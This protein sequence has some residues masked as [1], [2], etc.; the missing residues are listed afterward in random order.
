MTDNLENFHYNVIIANMHEMYSF[1]NKQIE[2]DIN[3]ETLINNYTKILI[4]INPIIPHYSNECLEMIGSKDE[5]SWPTYENKYLE[6][7][8]INIVVQ[9]N[10]KK[11]ALIEIEKDT[12]EQ[13]IINL[14]MSNEK[15]FKY[16][17]NKEIKKKIFIKNKVINFIL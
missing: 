9:I 5:I 12:I 13:D 2:K 11:R 4:A 16:F 10:G 7:K 15:L 14:I 6:E 3:Y 1:L 8:N 17:Q